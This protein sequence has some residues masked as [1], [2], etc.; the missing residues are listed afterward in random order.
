MQ[1]QTQFAQHRPLDVICLGRLAI[2]LYAKQLGARL[3]DA[4][5]FAR[6]LGG[7]SANIAFGTARLGLKSAMLSRVGDEHM[8]RYLLDTLTQEGCDV[9]QVKTDP[10]RLTALVLLGIKDRDTFPLIFYRENCADMA[11]EEAD[12]DPEFIASSKALLITGTHFSTQKV[13]AASVKALEIARANNVRT[14]LDIDYRPVL[15]GLTSRG[16]GEERFVASDGVSAHL[17]KVLPL[18]DLIVGTEE[19]FLIAGGKPDLLGCLH[20]VRHLA[21]G[22]VLVVKRGPLGCAVIP[23]DIPEHIDLAFSVKGARVEVMNV[24]GA[25]DAFLSGF[26]SGWINGQDYGTCCRRANACGALVVSRHGCSPAMPTSAELDYFLSLENTPV[27]PWEDATLARLH[28]VSIKRKQWSNLCVF[29]FDHRPQF[30][31]LAQQNGVPESRIS[32]LKS[33]LVK[34]VAETEEANHLQGR[35]GILVDDRYGE[36]AMYAATG[37]GWWI[38][39]P[40]ELPGSN[41]LE[42][43]HGRTQAARLESWPQE[44]IIKCLVQYHPDDTVENRLE[45]EA[46]VRAMYD[47]AQASGHELL[48]EVI[49]SKKLPQHP[50]TVL[51]ALKRF[52][53]LGIY[54][55]WWKL[56]SMSASQWEG[57]DS[58]IE[59]RDPYCRGVVLL[60]LNAP[61]DVLRKGFEEARHSR[62]C[63]G[64]MVGR[65]LFQEP[66]LRWLSGSIDDAGLVAE[67]RRNFEALIDIWQAQRARG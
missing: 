28:R 13:K 8:G 2:D 43:E 20:T 40:V 63:Q 31:E 44:H 67:A 19:E 37:R 33:L 66:S 4:T 23:G 3:E 47:A 48:L 53:N 36:D 52:Y 30:F 62:T 29:A 49:P 27:R 39:R 25:G 46:Q 34:A 51:R 5:S 59:E 41:P 18:F 42:F 26:L 10:D 22:A 32:Q 14:I 1:N 17:Q 61:V 16:N 65:T 12:I 24:L 54:P 15:W 11:L 57:I 55:E 35:I 21:P 50:D 45:Q 58:L 7:S 60:G 56:E 9:S 38:G 64:F 6:Y